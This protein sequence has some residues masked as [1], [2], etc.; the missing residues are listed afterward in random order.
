LYVRHGDKITPVALDDVQWIE[1]AGDYAK[2]HTDASTHLCSLGIGALD[3]RLD[4][5]FLRVHRSAI[6]ALDAIDHLRSDGSGGYVATLD[7]GTEVRV[8][9]SYAGAIRD[10][11]V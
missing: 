11:I 6:V 9:R 10:R 1:A 8:S 3:E 2:L 4:D 7:D 5:R